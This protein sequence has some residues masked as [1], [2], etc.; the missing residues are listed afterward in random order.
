[1]VDGNGSQLTSSALIDLPESQ[2]PLL[3]IIRTIVASYLH[4]EGRHPTATAI[5]SRQP[6][7]RPT[8]R[9]LVERPRSTTFDFIRHDSTT[10][11]TRTPPYSR[12]AAPF[13]EL[14]VLA[15]AGSPGAQPR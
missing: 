11:L 15:G 7:R 5:T 12:A 10:R 3:A 13:A 1:M 9:A 6:R 14:A 4:A 8:V 2:Y